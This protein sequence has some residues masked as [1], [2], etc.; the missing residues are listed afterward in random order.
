M[1]NIKSGRLVV[2]TAG[3]R[4]PFS[5]TS[6]RVERIIIDAETDNTGVVVVGDVTV[7]A[8]LLSRI[9]TP[10]SATGD[11]EMTRIE[12]F[13]VNLKDLYLDALV[14]T[15]GVTYTYFF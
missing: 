5:A 3:T 1:M 11:V 6:Q 7:V 10:L 15:D 14:S 2:A 9:G 4:V 13:D 8:T 12:L